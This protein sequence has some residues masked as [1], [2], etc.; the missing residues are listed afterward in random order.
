[1]KPDLLRCFVLFRESQPP[2]E[3][4]FFRPQLR[5]LVGADPLTSNNLALNAARTQ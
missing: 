2:H 4:P 1:V 3:R 5:L